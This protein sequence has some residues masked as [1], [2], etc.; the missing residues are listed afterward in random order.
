MS[1]ILEWK[2]RILDVYDDYRQYIQLILK[3]IL[4]FIIFLTINQQLGYMHLINN[5]FVV[6]IVSLLCAILP[7]SAIVVFGGIMILL[8]TFALGLE[9]GVLTFVF[10]LLIYLLF[11]RFT[12]KD[13][14][15]VVI[16]PAAC[17]IGIPGVVP[18]VAGLL[19]GPVSSIS[20]CIG[21]FCFYY[22]QV[23]KKVIK[24]VKSAGTSDMLE[25]LQKMIQGVLNNKALLIFMISG[26]AAAIIVYA[27]RRMSIKYAWYL[28][29]G[30]GCASYII[31]TAVFSGVMDAG[32]SIF[33][34][35]FGTIVSGAIALVVDFF[36]FNADY[37]SIENLQ[38]EDDSYF[39]YVKAVPKKRSDAKNKQWKRNL[40]KMNA[41]KPINIE[42]HNDQ[43]TDTDA[44]E[45][46]MDVD[47]E[48]KLEKSLD[49]LK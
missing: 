3:F 21:I 25:N 10:L 26:A 18:L 4:A 32:I 20:V 19:G 43:D 39:Y 46:Y 36:N 49:E 14:L 7:T 45:K 29:I 1:T 15:A 17:S 31:I 30:I 42:R 37:R 23:I 34:L 24:P 8:H 44:S 35:F 6:L 28:A 16:T 27:I 48:E 12:P 41:D 13:A 33:S 47:F 2:E 40:S 38:Y 5:M 9:A 11:F 22:L